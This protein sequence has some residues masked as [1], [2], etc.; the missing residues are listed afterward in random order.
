ML[1]LRE[2]MTRGESETVIH[3]NGKVVFIGFGRRSKRF[4][5]VVVARS[6]SRHLQTEDDILPAKTLQLKAC[7][8]FE[9]Q[10]DDDMLFQD[11]EASFIRC[12][13]HVPS[14]DVQVAL[15]GAF[16]VQLQYFCIVKARYF[17]EPSE[18]LG[19]ARDFIQQL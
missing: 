11:E 4:S 17:S 18:E 8:F 10:R 16:E 2:Q 5:Q 7:D 6:V 13:R 9:C 15:A 19:S 3:H 12:V 14:V 1:S